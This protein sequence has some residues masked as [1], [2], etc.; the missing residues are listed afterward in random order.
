MKWLCKLGHDE[1]RSKAQEEFQKWKSTGEIIAPNLQTAYFCGAIAVGDEDD[2][3][4]LYS[5]YE[6]TEQTPALQ[7]TRIVNGLGC[8]ENEEVIKK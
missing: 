7:R 4:F 2:F 3:D 1:C 8:S 6:E 5:K